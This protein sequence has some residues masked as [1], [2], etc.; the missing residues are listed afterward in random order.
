VYLTH[1]CMDIVAKIREEQPHT[2]NI[3]SLSEV[4]INREPTRIVDKLD[5]SFWKPIGDDLEFLKKAISEDESEMRKRVLEIQA[6]YAPPSFILIR[7]TK[8]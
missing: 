7:S 2:T 8:V 4:Q 6:K 3:S 5:S 1:H